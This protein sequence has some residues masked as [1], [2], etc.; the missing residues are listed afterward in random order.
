MKT[1]SCR[2]CPLAECDSLIHHSVDERRF[3]EKFRAGEMAVEA[4]TQILL[5]GSSAPQFYTVLD[6]MGLRDKTLPDGRRQ[7]INFVMPGDLLGLQASIMGEL[8]HSIEAVTPMRLCVFR[9]DDIWTLFRQMPE[10]SYA[11]TWIAATEEHFL[12]ETIASIGQRDGTERVSWALLKLYQRMR[13]LGLGRASRIPLPYRQQDLADA[14]GLS[15][16]HTNKTLAKLRERR[17][18]DWSHHELHVPDLKALAELAVADL[19]A[20]P[21]RPYL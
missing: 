11:L 9:R 10:L 3:L 5:E 15:L 20:P 4:G 17:V 2:S 7:V 19:D 6:G 13:A 16:V 1:V 18:A 21:K 12:G 14:L 8:N